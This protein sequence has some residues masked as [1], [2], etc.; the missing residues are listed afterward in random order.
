MA[1]TGHLLAFEDD[2]Q[3]IGMTGGPVGLL[4]TLLAALA[5]AALE[6]VTNNSSAVYWPGM[7][8]HLYGTDMPW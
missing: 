5:S 4:W 2:R 7:Y 1:K 6:T 3:V 8:Y